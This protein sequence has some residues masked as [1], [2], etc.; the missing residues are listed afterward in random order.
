[1]KPIKDLI[2]HLSITGTNKSKQWKFTI[3]QEWKTIIGKLYSKVSIYKIYNN[4]IVLGVYD[5][6]WMQELYMLSE[7]I[8]QKINAK[9]EQPYIETIRFKYI[10]KK[11]K[12]KN[13]NK[14][15]NSEKIK[16]HMLTNKEEAA[17]KKINDPEL[18]QALAE[19]L[20]KCHQ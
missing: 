13:D 14:S 5:L 12:K 19:L 16:E 3:M 4:S 9:L 2:P 20:N 6:N 11:T 17:L 8:K 1:M 7:V 10:T 18:S 15:S